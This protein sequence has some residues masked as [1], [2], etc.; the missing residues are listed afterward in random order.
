MP[1]L[2]ASFRLV[3]TPSGGRGLSGILWFSCVL[4]YLWIFLPFYF[5]IGRLNM[6]E[7]SWILIFLFLVF[8]WTYDY[9]CFPHFL[10][11]ALPQFLENHCHFPYCHPAVTFS[12]LVLPQPPVYCPLTRNNKETT[13]NMI[14]RLL[15]RL[16]PCF[17]KIF[18]YKLR[19]KAVFL[20][21]G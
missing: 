3:N 18:P 17:L 7:N 2:F 5:W 4:R 6:M 11:V 16:S 13:R 9:P 15:G 19:E 14:L 12:L 20:R 21:R 1:Y 10:F 8:P